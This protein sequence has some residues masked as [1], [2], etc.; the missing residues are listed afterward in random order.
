[1]WRISTDHR[2]TADEYFVWLSTLIQLQKLDLN[3]TD[4]QRASFRY[5]KLE[6]SKV[7]PEGS[8]ASL[9]EV[10]RDITDLTGTMCFLVGMEQFPMKVAR[11]GHIASRV[12]KVVELLPLS[13]AEQARLKDALQIPEE[14]EIVSAA[15]QIARRLQEARDEGRRRA[16]AV[17]PS[18]T[19]SGPARPLHG[20]KSA[21][22]HA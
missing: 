14:E 4:T 11:H 15:L 16:A 3:I 7:R 17:D 21:P 2:R 22:S 9:L 19:T 10:V 12:A 5:S 20:A 1:M 18:L 8:S 6:Q 13:P